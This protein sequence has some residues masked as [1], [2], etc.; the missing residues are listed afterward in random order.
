MA[1]AEKI[2]RWHTLLQLV[3]QQ[4]IQNSLQSKTSPETE[5]PDAKRVNEQ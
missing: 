5:K 2:A 4:A 3:E 1:E